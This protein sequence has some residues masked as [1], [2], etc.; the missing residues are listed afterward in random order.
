MSF[1]IVFL[2]TALLVTGAFVLAVQRRWYE[3]MRTRH[4]TAWTALGEP[5]LLGSSAAVQW[6]VLRFVQAGGY[7]N[8]QDA[9]LD[10]LTRSL[11]RWGIFYIA[12]FVLTVGVFLIFLFT[13]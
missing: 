8:L 3:Y 12:L 1:F 13:R 11:R 9:D 7:R 4:P 5:R 6:R 2:M 10:T